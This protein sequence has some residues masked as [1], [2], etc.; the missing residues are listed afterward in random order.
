MALDFYNPTDKR[1]QHL[2]FQLDDLE[3]ESLDDVITEY[4]RR[5]GLYLDPYRDT[6][7]YQDHINLLVQLMGEQ[8]NYPTKNKH[9]ETIRLQGIISKFSLATDGLLAIGD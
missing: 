6:Y 2:L 4:K 8:L 1:H 7:L 5:T 3:L 9:A